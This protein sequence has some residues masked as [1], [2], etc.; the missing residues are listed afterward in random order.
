MLS[1]LEK[2]MEIIFQETKHKKSWIHSPA[3]IA[4]GNDKMNIGEIISAFALCASG[5]G[6]D[7]DR[8]LML[9]TV[10]SIEV[11]EEYAVIY[12]HDGNTRNIRVYKDGRTED[13][14]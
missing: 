4:E 1:S 10:D 2:K 9:K 12:F 13:L 11:Y 6:D 5:Y 8:Y 14:D 7:N 3:F